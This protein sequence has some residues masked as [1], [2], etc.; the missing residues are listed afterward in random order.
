MRKKISHVCENSMGD[1]IAA[2]ETYGH[3]LIMLISRQRIDILDT[4]QLN[5][6]RWCVTLYFKPQTSTGVFHLF[7]LFTYST[8]LPIVGE[9]L[10]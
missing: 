7:P 9:E 4:R 8:I 3:F 5:F 10:E 6:P 2:R 1:S